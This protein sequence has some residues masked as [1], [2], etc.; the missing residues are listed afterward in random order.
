MLYGWVAKIA[1]G[2]NATWE[3]LNE[4]DNERAMNANDIEVYYSDISV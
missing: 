4:E 1:S 2:S 3:Q